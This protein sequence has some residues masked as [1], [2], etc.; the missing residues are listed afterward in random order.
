MADDRPDLILATSLGEAKG[1]L[2]VAAAVAVAFSH[3]RPA[4][5]FVEFGAGGRR[6]PTMLASGSAR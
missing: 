3:E 1:G 4:T 6:G 5:L 2:A